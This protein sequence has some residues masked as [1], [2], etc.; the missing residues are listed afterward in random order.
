[1]TTLDMQIDVKRYRR[2]GY[3]TASA[4]ASEAHLNAMRAEADRLLA[5]CANEPARSLASRLNYLRIN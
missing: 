3:L 2:D 1:M 4:V 5:V